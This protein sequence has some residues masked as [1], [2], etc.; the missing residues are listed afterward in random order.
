MNNNPMTERIKCPN[1][2]D[3][4][5]FQADRSNPIEIAVNVFNVVRLNTIFQRTKQMM[6]CGSCGYSSKSSI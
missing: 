3:E 2:G 6:M 4:L 1:C 5:K